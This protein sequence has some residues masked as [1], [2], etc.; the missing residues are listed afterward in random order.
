[1]LKCGLCQKFACQFWHRKFLVSCKCC[2]AEHC[3]ACKSFNSAK[4]VL[5]KSLNN[6][7]KGYVQNFIRDFLSLLPES[8]KEHYQ[9]AETV[10]IP[11]EKKF[12]VKSYHKSNKNRSQV[13]CK[14]F[15]NCDK[16][17]YSIKGKKRTFYKKI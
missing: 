3:K 12:D 15:E 14:K 8:L 9:I 5:L 4:E 13:V 6:T 11:R 1:M 2:R 7:A 10:C 16:L 17:N